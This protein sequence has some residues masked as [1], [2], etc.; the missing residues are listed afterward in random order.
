MRVLSVM[1]PVIVMTCPAT[2]AEGE[3]DAAPSQGAGQA[4]RGQMIKAI[5]K[6]LLTWTAPLSTLPD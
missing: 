4:H 2:E 3:G 5:P 1:L 6:R